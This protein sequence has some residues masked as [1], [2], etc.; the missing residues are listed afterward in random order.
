MT[1]QEL[2]E[3]AIRY[4]LHTPDNYITAE[5]AISPD[6]AG[7]QIYEA[8]I[9]AF[10]A[11]ED[12]AFTGLQ[13]P[14][15]IGPHF[16]LPRQWLAQARTVV[17]LFL[18]F[19]KDVKQSNARALDWP[20]A[21]WLHGRIEG[22][23]CSDGLC[24]YLQAEL[25]NDGYPTIVP[26]LQPEFV[27]ANFSSNWSERHVAFICGLG[28]FGISKGLITEK[29]M[30]GRLCSLVTAWE[31]PPDTR[32]YEDLYAYCIRCGKCARNC[33]AQAISPEHGKDHPPC[34]A[35]L[36]ITKEKYRPRYGCGKCQV[37]VPCSDRR[38]GNRAL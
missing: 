12:E 10:G 1:R 3:K 38:P 32:A 9:F 34:S 22:Q 5:Q 21:E 33:P 27:S 14:Q 2:I 35:F 25:I 23:I 4:T 31:T 24:R 37:Q 20:S 28:T 36:N 26:T 18:P 16:R 15:V 7:L 11:A 29:G 17:S 30:A 8:P 6:L 19:S 13:D